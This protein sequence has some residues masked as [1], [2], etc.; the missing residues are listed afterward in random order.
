MQS[1]KKLTLKLSAWKRETS[2]KLKCMNMCTNLH[3]I[4]TI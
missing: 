3:S 1:Y 2:H 4:N